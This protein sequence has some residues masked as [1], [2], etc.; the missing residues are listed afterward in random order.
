MA[1]INGSL[2]SV[3]NDHYICVDNVIA[4]LKVGRNPSAPI[5]RLIDSLPEE[6][7]LDLTNKKG[8][9]SLIVMRDANYIRSCLSASVVARR[10]A[11][12]KLII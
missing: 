3:G 1:V 8:T 5:K 10:V 9:K 11:E 4:I 7:V 6:C 2:I 12:A